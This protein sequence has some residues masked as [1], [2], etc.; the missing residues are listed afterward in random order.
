MVTSRI[1]LDDI[2]QKGFDELL[3]RKDDH[4]KI[5]VTPKEANIRNS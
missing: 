5:M 4:I 2:S 3:Q 1:H